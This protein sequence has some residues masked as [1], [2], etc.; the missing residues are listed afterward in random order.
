VVSLR[1]IGSPLALGFLGMAGGTFT[2]AGL[3]LGWIGAGQSHAV[4]LI[5]LAFV[6]PAQA[7][8][9]VYGFLARDSVA[10]TGM[11]ILAVAWLSIGSVMATSPP[12]VTSGA[13]GLMLVMAGAALWVPVAASA[14]NKLAASAVLIGAS[15]RFF[16][17]GAYELSGSRVWQSA[18]GI[19]GVALAG[20]ALYAALALELEDNKHRTVLPTLRA[21]EGAQAFNGDPDSELHSV[22]KEAGVRNQL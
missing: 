5:L 21:G 12:A 3:E 18:A 7:L 8:A 4:A 14:A 13:E 9:S 2:L 10:G 16:L 20:I 22:L 1:P 11:G 19:A 17:S 15:V 6:V